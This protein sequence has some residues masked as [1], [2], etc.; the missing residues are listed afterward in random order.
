MTYQVGDTRRPTL[1]IDVFDANTVVTLTVICV[2]TGVSTAVPVT[3]A[4]GTWTA[5]AAYTLTGPGK[6]VEQ[7]RAT[8]AVT[9]LGAGS[10]TVE[11]DV[12]GTPP[13][14]GPGQS[15]AYAT[16][17]Q[18]TQIIGGAI[19]D[20]LAR[21]LRIAS[22]QIDKHIHAAVYDPT[23]VNT[24]A[25]LVE[26]CCEQ[27]AWQGVNGWWATGGVPAMARTVTLGSASIGA[28]TSSTAGGGVTATVPEL[29]AT[30]FTLLWEAGLIGGQPDVFGGWWGWGVS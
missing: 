4:G 7:W 29:S 19:P 20:N 9:G 8:N 21:M 28:P 30:A 26:A 24:I 2:G 23:D 18:Y 15:G 1:T 17:L 27:V 11:I 5:N 22:R 12:E 25:A 6:W 16:V 3:G 13:A 10:A 14:L